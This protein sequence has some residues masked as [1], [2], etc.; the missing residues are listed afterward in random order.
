MGYLSKDDIHCVAT[1]LARLVKCTT[2]L[3]D[4]ICTYTLH[5]FLH[6]QP[7]SIDGAYDFA[8]APYQDVQ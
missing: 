6:L 3:F 1:G 8:Y 4:S 7:Q 5:R 2:T